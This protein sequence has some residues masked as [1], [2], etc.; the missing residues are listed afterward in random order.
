ME[1]AARFLRSEGDKGASL[2]DCS[3]TG[4][5]ERWMHQC[6]ERRPERGDLQLASTLETMKRGEQ[7]TSGSR[8]YER[9]VQ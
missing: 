8:Y 2:V 7:L 6:W 5:C 3:G 1:S 4:S 9:D